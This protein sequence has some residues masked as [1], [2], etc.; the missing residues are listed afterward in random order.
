MS[1]DDQHSSVIML[2]HRI[3]FAACLGVLSHVGGFIHGEHH[4][5]SSMY[6]ALYTLI[7]ALLFGAQLFWS[8]GDFAEARDMTLFL[9]FAYAGALFGS[10]LIYRIFFHRL[11]HFRG[12]YM[13]KVSKFWNVAHVFRSKNYRLM[14]DMRRS[15]GDFVRTGVSCI[16][17]DLADVD[18]PCSIENDRASRTE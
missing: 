17:C 18:S 12:P 10:M 11:R 15:Y 2:V 5:H 6:F 1:I 13:A 4:I 16:L 7:L 9:A 3:I 14:E 8:D